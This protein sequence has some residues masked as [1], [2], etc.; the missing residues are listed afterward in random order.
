MTWSGWGAR[1]AG[2]LVAG[3]ILA[4]GP[5][6]AEV[7]TGGVDARAIIDGLVLPGVRLY[8][9]ASV[10]DLV[11]QR[12]LAVSGPSIDNG[13]MTLELPPGSYYLA[14]KKLASG[15][16]DGPLAIG[17]LFGYQGSNPVNVAPGKRSHA[18]FVLFRKEREIAFEPA[19]DAATGSI[20]GTLVYQGEPLP[21]ARVSLYIG[22]DDHFRGQ[23]H[24]A[25]PPTGKSGVFRIDN[26][27]PGRYFL[28]ARRR[29]SGANAGPIGDGDF[30]GYFPE[31]P[32]EVRAGMATRL[33]FPVGSKAGE[34][35]RDDD[36]FHESATQ[37]RG[38]IVD[39]AG[40]PVAGAHAFGYRDKSMA[41]NRPAVIS[42]ET[43][44]DGV[45]VLYLERGGAWY[46]GARTG[47]GEAPAPGELFGRYDGTA[48]HSVVVGD[49]KVVE[50][51]DVR[52][53]PTPP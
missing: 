13:T 18:G 27:P 25:A 15:P 53:A 50:G 16:G 8:A 5:L 6:P 48:D 38:R 41:G 35:G 2:C 51:I 46:L 12:P 32:V 1:V 3:A 7:P 29:A 39:S 10:E 28:I 52:V 22:G 26:L 47:Y 45:Y 14:A 42:R 33:L 40:S 20:A 9:Y 24:S 34:I 44:P 19:G 36:L 31:N 37:A 11:R 49:G 23:V 43:G 30:F 4:A 21:G 17:D